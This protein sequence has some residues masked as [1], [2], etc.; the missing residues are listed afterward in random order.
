MRVERLIGDTTD[1]DRILQLRWFATWLL[2]IGDGLILT[3]RVGSRNLIQ[4]PPQMICRSA[5][6]L[7]DTVFPNFLERHIDMEWLS[8]RAC[9]G[10]RNDLVQQRN[11]EMIDLLPGDIFESVSINLCVNDEDNRFY[12]TDTLSQ[13]E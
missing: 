3:N 1:F 5:Q 10:C 11:N 4:M 9:L 13:Q 12:D 7:R 6:E 2:Q 8:T